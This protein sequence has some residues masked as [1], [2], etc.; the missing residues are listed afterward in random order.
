[1]NPFIDSPPLYGLLAMVLAGAF[2]PKI[3]A[4]D[5]ALVKPTSQQEMAH[6][7]DILNRRIQM[8][9][10]RLFELERM[11]IVQ[12]PAGAGK[13]P[14]EA[15]RAPA[16]QQTKTAASKHAPGEFEV[17]EDAAE[18]ALERTLIKEGALLLRFGQMD[19]T[20]T[21]SFTRFTSTAPAFLKSSAGADIVDLAAN[22]E[23]RSI[24]D[25]HLLARLGLPYDAQIE[26]GVPYRYVDESIVGKVNFAEKQEAADHNSGLGD[27]SIGLAKTLMTEADGWPTDL[28]ARLQWNTGSGDDRVDTGV[29]LGF[30]TEELGV[31]LGMTK[32]QDPLVFTGR[33]GYTKTFSKDG[34]D[35]GDR[36]NLSIAALLAASP[37]TSL[38]I[39][40]DQTFSEAY[41]RNGVTVDG[42]DQLSSMLVLGA[43]S[44][45]GPRSFLNVSIGAGLTE[46]APDYNLGVSYTLR[47]SPLSN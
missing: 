32:R 8:L 18:R 46:D 37:D 17:D 2:S 38:R 39:G 30:S 29:P 10:R 6:K 15:S 22:H 20:T 4:A 45:L 47:F 35:P 41:S 40:L 21:L 27:L 43:S 24:T 9:E 3:Q 13:A 14:A 23:R 19:L 5:A 16:P 12:P 42:S 25:L 7:I 33:L 34:F 11:Q 36:W 31:S 28:I 26:L 44:I 1:M